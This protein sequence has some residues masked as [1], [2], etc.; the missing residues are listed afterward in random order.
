[1][2]KLML[3]CIIL[4]LF[5]H[6]LA[7]E[8]N[9]VLYLHNGSIIRGNIIQYNDTIVKILTVG[10][11]VFAYTPDQI[12]NIVIEPVPRKEAA[13]SDSGFFNFFSAGLLFGHSGDE[14]PAPFSALIESVYKYKENYATGVFIGFE[15]L[16]ENIVPMGITFKY[17]I[18]VKKPAILIGVSGGYAN[19]VEKPKDEYI[20]KAKGGIIFGAEAGII[21]PLGDGYGIFVSAGYRYTGLNYDIEDWWL[22]DYKRKI[23]FNRLLI[24]MGISIF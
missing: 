19:P 23:K 15:Q 5:S 1:M 2:K 3:F 12:R 8:T 6:V 13:I 24:R 17:M 20:T 7:Q 22:G 4:M 9:D 18:P 10:D 16:K 14:K 11:N 21:L